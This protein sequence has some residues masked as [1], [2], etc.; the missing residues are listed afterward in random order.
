[1]RPGLSL[2]AIRTPFRLRVTA[3][4]LIVFM[5]HAV[6]FPRGVFSQTLKTYEQRSKRD[7]ESFMDRAHQM[8]DKD[9]WTNYVE[10]GIATER[11]EWELE[12]REAVWQRYAEIGKEDAPA[13]VKNLE[14]AEA[15]AA[16]TDAQSDWE[17]DAREHLIAE[18]GSF[19][20]D[21]AKDSLVDIKISDQEYA[22]I[23]AAAQDAV[24]GLSGLD[25][26]VYDNA[27][28]AKHDPLARRFLDGLGASLEKVRAGNVDLTGAEKQA[29]ETQLSA[30]EESIRSEFQIRDSFWMKR[31]RNQY[32]ALKRADDVSARLAADQ[33]SADAIGNAVI[34]EAELSL[35]ASTTDQLTS[36]QADIANL[37]SGAGALDA[38][39]SWQERMESLITAGMT[40]WEKA[41]EDLYADRVA[42][43]SQTKLTRAEGVKIWQSS[44]DKLAL[45]RNAWLRAVQKQIAEGRAEWE[46]KTADF[47]SARTA[48]EQ[49][50]SAF[51]TGEQTRWD[52]NSKELG[53]LV[54]GG[55]AALLEAKDAYNY[56]DGL[57]K[58]KGIPGPGA[59][60]EDVELYNFYEA[61]RAALAKSIGRFQSIL[62][63]A[64]TSLRDTLHSEQPS[65]GLLTDKRVFFN[66]MEKEAILG[67][68]ES[69]FK[70]DLAARAAAQPEEYLLYKRDF[71]DI[72][73]RNALFVSRTAEL[74]DLFVYQA[75]LQIED[76]R[77][78]AGRL[79]Q[80]Y[81]EHAAEIL[82]ILNKDRT[83]L[84]DDAARLAAA[85]EEIRL[86]FLSNG[87]ENARLKRQITSYLNDSTGGYY[88]TGNQNDPYLMTR[89]EFEWELLRRQRDAMA[90]R[91]RRAEAVKRYADLAAMH[92]AGLELASV[93]REEVDA[94]A[95]RSHIREI[96]YH[97]LN[98]DLPVNQLAQTDSSVRDAEYARLLQTRGV[99]VS[100]LLSREESISK[101]L[102]LLTDMT[103]AAPPS[104]DSASTLLERIDA[105]IASGAEAAGASALT[106]IRAKLADFLILYDSGAAS[107]V[108]GARWSVLSGA[109]GDVRSQLSNLRAE[110]D[111]AGLKAELEALKGAVA[112]A[113]LT[114]FQGTLSTM[115][116]SMQVTQTELSQARARLETARAAYGE[117]LNDY[118][119]LRLGNADDVIKLELSQSSQ[120]LAAILN[121]M[122]DIE[123]IPGFESSTLFTGL[124]DASLAKRLE[125]LNAVG[126]NDQARSDL[127]SASTT[128]AA[129]Q[130]LE[131]S[132][133]RTAALGALLSAQGNLQG[134]APEELVDI[135]TGAP[136]IVQKGTGANEESLTSTPAVLRILAALSSQKAALKSKRDALDQVNKE[137]ALA[138]TGQAAL[139]EKAALLTGAILEL[140][141]SIRRDARNL[142]D[143]IHFEEEARRE[144]V[145]F[146]LGVTA[147]SKPV[148]T[149]ELVQEKLDTAW[150]DPGT[151][152]SQERTSMQWSVVRAWIMGNKTVIESL[153]AEPGTKDTRSTDEKWNEFIK[154]T[155]D[156]ASDTAFFR[157]FQSRIPVGPSSSWA[158]N[159]TNVRSALLEGIHGALSGNDSSLLTFWQDL[160]PDQRA[161]I[162]RYGDVNAMDLRGSIVR[163]ES[164]VRADI[165]AVPYAYRSLFYREQAY[166]ASKTLEQISPVLAGRT[167]E[168][169]QS[170]SEERLLTADR[171]TM[172]GAL[173][174]LLPGDPQI[175][176][177][178]SRMSDIDIRIEILRGKSRDLR[179]LIDDLESQ[180]RNAVNTLKE[181]SREG[182]SSVLLG[183]TAARMD[184]ASL[185]SEALTAA[186]LDMRLSVRD[187]GPDAPRITAV[188]QIKGILG[189]YD[190]DAQGMIV[191]TST[192]NAVISQEFSAL[193]FT[194]TNFEAKIMGGG[195]KG[196][197]LF[198]W[199]VRLQT[200]A[201][202]N[203]KSGSA[204][205][206][207]RAAAELVE[208]SILDYLAAEAYIKYRDM[209]EQ[210]LR[211]LAKA[212]IEEAAVLAGRLARVAD[213][214]AH[215]RSLFQNAEQNGSDPVP[216]LLL[217][218]G[219]AETVRLLKD[220]SGENAGGGVS[221]TD[222]SLAE[223]AKGILTLTDRLR[224]ADT[225][226]NNAEVI[227][228]Y[229]QLREQSGMTVTR[230]QFVEA[231]AGLTSDVI[232]ALDRV[233]NGYERDAV[234]LPA[235]VRE[236]IADLI[237][238]Y[239]VRAQPVRETMNGALSGL[240]GVSDLGQARQSLMA[241]L[242]V[243]TGAEFATP[244][245]ALQAIIAGAGDVSSLKLSVQS[246]LDSLTDPDPAMIDQT[247]GDLYGSELLRTLSVAGSVDSFQ[248]VDW[249]VDLRTFILVY[250]YQ[251]ASSRY[252]GYQDL[253][254]SSAASQDES[255]VL[256]LSGLLGDMARFILAKDLEAFAAET[257]A[258]PVAGTGNTGSI[259]DARARALAHGESG[260]Y[261]LSDYFSAYFASRN[262]DSTKMPALNQIAADLLSGELRRI[263]SDSVS[264]GG[265]RNIDE[266]LYLSD[267][268]EYIL[269]AK[270]QAYMEAHPFTL[271]G[272]A[273]GDRMSSLKP[274]FD[275]FLDDSGFATADGKT[276][277]Q[278]LLNSAA[279]TGL[280]NA[281]FSS[282]DQGTGPE[283]CLPSVLGP[284]FGAAAAPL[285]TPE[286]FLPAAL[287]AITGY[288]SQDY[289]TIAASLH[290]RVLI[291]L[292]KLE[293]SSQEHA[294]DP[295]YIRDADLQSM[296]DVA[297][298][299]ALSASARQ[300]LLEFLRSRTAGALSGADSVTMASE[301][302]RAYRQNKVFAF[303]IPD[304]SGSADIKAFVANNGPLA[305]SIETKFFQGL[306]AQ[307]GTDLRQRAKEDRGAMIGAL[308]ERYQG[309]ESVFY[310]GLT[311]DEKTGFERLKIALLSGPQALLN[312]DEIASLTANRKDYV[313]FFL[314]RSAQELVVSGL[315]E[316][317]ESAVMGQLARG[318]TPGL[319]SLGKS[320]RNALV[321]AFVDALYSAEGSESP[322]RAAMD[323]ALLASNPG[324]G[325][326]IAAGLK[327]MDPD[328]KKALIQERVLV[329]RFLDSFLE[330]DAE[331]AL[332]LHAISDPA[333]LH[334]GADLSLGYEAQKEFFLASQDRREL[335]GLLASG[336]V[337]DERIVKE[338]QQRY[339][340]QLETATRLQ[341]FADLRGNDV[342]LSRFSNY[343]TYLGQERAYANPDYEAY[344]AAQTAQGRTPLGYN[345]WASGLVVE[346]QSLKLSAKSI[347]EDGSWRTSLTSDDQ[348][349]TTRM[350]LGGDTPGDPSDDRT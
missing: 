69:H 116:A 332:I 29:F 59:S 178:S 309:L 77:L 8:R 340:R 341:T 294:G 285:N 110:Y 221:L 163:V 133:H 185:R 109:V 220:I 123:K 275:A 310:N 225:T 348:A 13:D 298:S 265:I 67:L 170:M 190:T 52:S 27:A 314:L 60:S 49:E 158:V 236:S 191:K 55:G 126:Q 48:A 43:L 323:N 168:L 214:E 180:Y 22:E 153:N 121:R 156:L 57:L 284:G 65:T 186:Q 122:T 81:S 75:A 258:D 125:Y 173:D 159:F 135:L 62:A 128:L 269:A 119:I 303:Y 120:S 206:E 32:V 96:S 293:L 208:T 16:Y 301:A 137:L 114:S 232:A 127:K 150:A 154:R 111:F 344:K 146:L 345:E 226:K 308:I 251:T 68:S 321:R 229:A 11:A 7:V 165:T 9:A 320:N 44:R 311:S 143:A 245:A 86:W 346:S 230:N 270:F 313:R 296:I 304:E 194:E 20:A 196:D 102:S 289:K 193:G 144:E 238:R 203:V 277:R 118:N 15:E 264:K 92:E 329:D 201:S 197:D 290:P 297:G 248:N 207:V 71:Q 233:D 187:G 164:A 166:T 47:E 224:E 70:S 337:D 82:A 35:E 139:A 56:Y 239:A 189:F 262:T 326:Q 247:A 18:R 101:E 336:L 66:A 287:K 87:N 234:L 131:A 162:R 98:G 33:A 235:A 148:S 172:Q 280:F 281:V 115:R 99:N 4:L 132:K 334:P 100:A 149:P 349:K 200:W 182:S 89:A 274:V 161:L 12:A 333:V 228:A 211:A 103:L 136:D 249:P 273:T 282:M 219:D 268:Q 138:D 160:S 174:A 286:D 58:L 39:R 171:A 343:R 1:M 73:D 324:L 325:E 38:N 199:A 61:Q 157:E 45:A 6:L 64:E 242:E 254:A 91:L 227:L 315:F 243:L 213:L 328:L 41:E 40:R 276:I 335:T 188:E 104:R 218:L 255:P 316:R 21:L 84:P 257:T 24:A 28:A 271:S 134:K 72:T 246:Y 76:L 283:A 216:G 205:P 177:L 305:A 23:L 237:S 198:R 97:L 195:L 256:D 252:E 53:D 167:Q 37:L 95:A 105:Y 261:Y 93:T 240:A 266:R 307:A 51:V 19:T 291:E 175:Q 204:A 342:K 217:L 272:S 54:N 107:A 10:L 183:F 112:Q 322:Q 259:A 223:R 94:A 147:G 42:W 108:V 106:G 209:P 130:G 46:K 78:L 14:R 30:L 141:E 319:W 202:D 184:T 88:L 79:N 26:A 250:E 231:H 215:M 169:E 318:G 129:V 295:P 179:A 330:S 253:R 74:E 300:E 36:A 222:P 34:Q 263:T 302:V 176:V 117:A 2:C 90:E 3:G 288:E 145:F 306:D 267:F 80:K 350:T 152:T 212:Q 278:R 292:T 260:S 317:T 210:D 63:G 25:L 155:G 181:C 192:G 279:I 113:P 31:G 244:R 124:A 5:A 339:A 327:A 142:V 50:L 83:S 331:R 85:K 312:S 347:F 17:A 151:L 140:E 338:T 299:A 241:A